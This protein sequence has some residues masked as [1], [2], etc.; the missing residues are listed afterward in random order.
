MAARPARGTASPW[1]GAG[2]RRAVFLDEVAAEVDAVA[3]QGE[4]VGGGAG[5]DHLLGVA[6]AVAANR[7]PERC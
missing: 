1:G 6:L 5:A 3:E 2:L 4:Q 7:R